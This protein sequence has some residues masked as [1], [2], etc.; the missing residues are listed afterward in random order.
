M[1]LDRVRDLRRSAVGE[2]IKARPFASLRDLAA[3]VAL[4]EKELR[5]LIQCGAL[6]GF[7]ESRAALLAK[8]GE[9]ARAGS[10]RQMAFA[11]ASRE[12][13]PETAE[14]RL[15]WERRILGMPVSVHPLQL[16]APEEGLVPL[17]GLPETNGRAVAVHGVRLPGWTG[18]PGIYVSDGE[19]FVRAQHEGQAPRAW[20]PLRVRGRWRKDAWGGGWLEAEEMVALR[21]PR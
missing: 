7:G 19:T 9:V 5:H 16:V 15:T 11:F 1:G 10:P 2:I 6:D 4:Q 14:E 17:Q 12:T 3:Q 13:T 21:S 18:A 8:A 20:Q